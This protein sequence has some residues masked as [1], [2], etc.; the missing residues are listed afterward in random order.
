MPESA[1]LP[2]SM[3][4]LI[5]FDS[6]ILIDRL[7]ANLFVSRMSAL[8]GL[9]RNSSVV[10]AEL[11]RGISLDRDRRVLLRL[12]GNYPIL[13]PSQ[14]NWLESG[15]ILAKIRDDVGFE[16]HKLRDLHFDVLIAL[17][18]RS[19]GARLITSNRVDFELIRKYRDF[20]LEAW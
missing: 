15:Q 2:G 5:I 20:K 11:W 4:E 17:T 10:L 1:R 18:A 7:R 12:Q 9:V 19:H 6:S 8:S 16:P 14:N 13:T 3:S